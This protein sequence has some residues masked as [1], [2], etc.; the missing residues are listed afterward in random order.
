MIVDPRGLAMRFSG[1]AELPADRL[2]H[3]NRHNRPGTAQNP[4][5]TLGNISTKSA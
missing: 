3:G 5:R 4:Y 2:A 1:S